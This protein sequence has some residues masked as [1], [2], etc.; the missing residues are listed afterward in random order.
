MADRSWVA[1][2]LGKQKV[3][4]LTVGKVATMNDPLLVRAT[5]FIGLFPNLA[6]RTFLHA[7]AVGVRL[8]KFLL[9]T[10]AHRPT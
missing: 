7:V 9:V 6:H 5:A 8:L 1:I 3:L 10:F 4:P 2:Y